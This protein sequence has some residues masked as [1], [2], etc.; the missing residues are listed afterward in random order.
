M[1]RAKLSPGR[2]AVGARRGAVLAAVVLLALALYGLAHV[3]LLTARGAHITANS[4]ARDMALRAATDGAVAEVLRD[5][6]GALPSLLG[7]RSDTIDHFIHGPH[8]IERTHLRLSEESWLIEATARLARGPAFTSRTVGWVPVPAVRVRSWPAVVSVAPGGILDARGDISG[9]GP[10][11]GIVERVDLGPISVSELVQHSAEVP[12]TVR[13]APVRAGSACVA[14]PA[15]W[16]APASPTHPCVDRRVAGAR[17]GD[18]EVLGGEGQ[19]LLVVDGDATLTS[20]TFHGLLLATGVV[21]LTGDTRVVGRIV[22]LGGFSAEP[23]TSVTG[24]AAVVTEALIS[25]M[26]V[27]PPVW[28]SHPARSLGPTVAGPY[29]GSH[30]WHAIRRGNRGPR[31]GT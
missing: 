10:P 9:D 12:P 3:L 29:P 8:T 27:W 20:T 1:T 18:L 15:N 5:G 28:P 14:A 2:R 24:S 6:L 11:L 31:H 21:R 23:A 16:G 7:V 26:R 25:A 22:A 30:P 13:P 19:G 17:T 4:Q